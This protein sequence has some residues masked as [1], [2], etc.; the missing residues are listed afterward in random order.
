MSLPKLPPEFLNLLK[1]VTGKRSR[2]VI[3]HILKHGKITTEDLERYGYRHPP[4]AI[5]DVR[6]QGIPIVKANVRNS[7]DTRTIA[8]YSFGDPNAAISGRIGGRRV[9]NKTFHAEVLRIFG[10]KCHI[11]QAAMEPRCLQIDHRLP[12]RV[13]GDCAVA[14]ANSEQFMPLCASCNRAKSWSCEHCKNWMNIHDKGICANCYWA[15]P[16]SYTH[17][18]MQDLRRIDV[19]WQGEEIAQYDSLAKAAAS[20]GDPLPEFVKAA[21]HRAMKYIKG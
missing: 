8:V 5:G 7:D 18:A 15:Y 6:D 1:C 4:R 11:C 10:C 14:S 19:V 21:L 16:K 9:I 13:L 2:I 3:D 20:H 17:I 12:Y